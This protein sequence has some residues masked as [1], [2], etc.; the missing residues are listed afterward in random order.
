MCEMPF[1]M[2]TVKCRKHYFSLFFLIINSNF[3]RF[4]DGAFLARETHRKQPRVKHEEAKTVITYCCCYSATWPA[5]FS[6]PALE[7]P[8]R[9]RSNRHHRP[10]IHSSTH[11]P[12]RVP[13]AVSCGM[14][15]YRSTG[16]VV[17]C[18][19]RRDV[20]LCEGAVLVVQ[21][22]APSATAGT[23]RRLRGAR[24]CGRRQRQHWGSR[25]GGEPL[26]SS[27][28]GARLAIG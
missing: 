10:S 6:T 22:L 20:R 1:E 17:R 25:E 8:M 4:N 27:S 9:V 3:R 11:Q 21:G 7:I 5:W 24:G 23:E 14:G 12:D 18:G 26:P 16:S 2:G 19:H 13:V 15:R 28:V